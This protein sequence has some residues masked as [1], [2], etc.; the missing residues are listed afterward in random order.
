M[1]SNANLPPQILNPHTRPKTLIMILPICKSPKI[2]PHQTG[3]MYKLALLQKKC[4]SKCFLPRIILERLTD[5]SLQYLH[6]FLEERFGTVCV[7]LEYSWF[8]WK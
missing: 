6:N 1:I 3:Y 4:P 5:I 7:L 2:A 8:V